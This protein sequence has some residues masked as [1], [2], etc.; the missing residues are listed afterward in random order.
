[1]KYVLFLDV[2]TAQIVDIRPQGKDEYITLN[3]ISFLIL[4][5]V[6]VPFSC[7]TGSI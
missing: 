4:F 1:M 7:G 2:E 5:T 3:M 6:H